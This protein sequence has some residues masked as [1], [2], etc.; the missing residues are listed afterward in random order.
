MRRW[1]SEQRIEETDAQSADHRVALRPLSEEDLRVVASWYEKGRDLPRR[2]E[3]AKVEPTACL[4]AVSLG[5]GDRPIG[6]VEYRVGVP[7]DGWLAFHSVAVEPRLRGLG[8]DSEAV[9]LVEDDALERGLASRFW[10]GVHHNDGLGFYFWLRLGY[11]PVRAD[12]AT[13]P[14]SSTQDA[15]SMI[16]MSERPKLRD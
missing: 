1:Q 9:G 5:E 14:G 4:L 8:L 2:L 6:V 16:R 10:A 3:E 7:D 11:R 13:W 12:E 15:M